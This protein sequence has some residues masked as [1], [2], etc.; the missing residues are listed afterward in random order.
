MTIISLPERHIPASIHH[1][2]DGVHADFYGRAA[3]LL[4]KP[5]KG[6]PPAEAW[7]VLERVPHLFRDLE[8]LSDSQTLWRALQGCG[9]PQEVLT[10]MPQPTGLLTTV[11]ADKR[12]WVA[13]HLSP[14]APVTTVANGPAK[15]LYA[16]PGRVLIDDIQRNID[17]WIAAGGIGILHV[18]AEDTLAQLAALGVR[19]T[20]TTAAA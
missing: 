3:K 6:T 9:L 10:A 13:R 7:A 5:Y 11:D 19:V 12:G 2:L 4:G 14:T 17:M 18:S 1:D 15:A 20:L 16:G 8:P